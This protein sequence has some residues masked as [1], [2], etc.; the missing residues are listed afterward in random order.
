MTPEIWLLLIISLIAIVLFSLEWIAAEVVALALMLTLIISGILTPGQAFAGF[1]SDTVMMI[2]GLLIMTASL[3]QT[4]VVDIVGRNIIQRTGDR[5]K[6]LLPVILI[7][8]SFLSAFISNTAATAFFLPVV[9]GLAAKLGQSA[10]RFLMPLAFASILSSSVTLIS[11]STNLVISELMTTHGLAPMS[12]FELAPAGIPITIAGLIYMLTI[13]PRLMPQQRSEKNTEDIGHRTYQA[14]LV[15]LAGST[16]VGKT[17]D[18]SKLE[19]D[20]DLKVQDIVRG[21]D[22]ADAPATVAPQQAELREGD[23]LLVE[24]LRANILKVKDVAGIELKADAHLVKETKKEIYP[25]NKKNGGGDE[26]DEEVKIVEA[27]LLPS[28]PLLGRTLRHID[29]NERYGLQVLGMNRAGSTMQSSMDRIHLKMGD[30]LLLQG[31][32][33]NVKRMERGNL[34]NIFGGIDQARLNYKR[35]PLAIL[36]FVGALAAA[37]FNLVAL[38]VAVLSGA[39]LVMVTGCIDPDEA[40]RRVEWKAIILIGSLLALGVALEETGTGAFLAAQ[41]IALLGESDPLVL[42]SC[43]FILTVALTQPMSNAAAAVLIVPIAIQTAVQL[44]YDPRPFVMMIAIAASCSFLTPLE[45]SC[46]MVY[47]PGKY[48]FIDF[49]K[50][51]LPLTVI[52]YAIAIVLVPMIW[53]LHGST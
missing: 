45:P 26:E 7:A 14:D 28:S 13:A 39:L 15:V 32:A 31:K 36:I 2:L 21:A 8:T 18:Q 10:S 23:V 51:G 17:L 22:S 6:L 1:G 3:L 34:V 9:I 27:V 35:A 53:P 44:G 30:V 33:E 16:L 12:M 38:P 11:T 25:A 52:I 41:I 47:G 37:T 5:P 19:K 4:G 50:V 20:L 24:G 42:F 29:F 49:F 43:F 40:Y 46:L 48:R